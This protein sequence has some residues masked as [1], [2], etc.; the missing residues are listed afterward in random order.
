MTYQ[1]LIDKIAE[2]RNI[3]KTEAREVLEGIFDTLTDELR[4]GVGVSIPKFGTFKT[5]KRDSRKVYSPHHKK[6]MI[7]PP[8]RVVDF[9]PSSSLKDNL[10]YQEPDDE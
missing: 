4:N 9:T 6:Y 3:P 10:K 1:E 8:K 2:S 5:R 7:V